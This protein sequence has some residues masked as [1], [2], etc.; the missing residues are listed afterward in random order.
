MV[1]ALVEGCRYAAV[2]N[3]GA[4]PSFDSD[5]RLLEVHVLDYSGDLYGLTMTVEFVQRLRPVVRFEDLGALVRQIE[6]D[7]QVAREVLSGARAP[8]P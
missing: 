1:W 5:A 4:S 8:Q 6:S 7:I 3:L 2:A